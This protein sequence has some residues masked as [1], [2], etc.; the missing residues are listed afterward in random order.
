MLL[1]CYDSPAFPYYTVNHGAFLDI[2][3]VGP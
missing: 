1:E 2:S 3:A